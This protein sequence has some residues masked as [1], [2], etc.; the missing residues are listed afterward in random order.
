MRHLTRP[1]ML[2]G[3]AGLGLWGVWRGLAQRKFASAFSGIGL[4][5]L[6]LMGAGAVFMSPGGLFSVSKTIDPPPGNVFRGM[7]SIGPSPDS[8]VRG[9]SRSIFD[10]IAVP[11]FCALQFG[12]V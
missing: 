1:W 11:G 10:A 6:A 5:L 8:S 3:L 12:D 4:S 9:M 7:G 2:A